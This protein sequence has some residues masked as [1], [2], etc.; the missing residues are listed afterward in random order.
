MATMVERL[1][2]VEDAVEQVQYRYGYI[3]DEEM[4]VRVTQYVGFAVR[5]WL[6]T[7]ALD[8]YREMREFVAEAA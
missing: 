2:L 3:T 8:Y 6:R 5:G 1:R 7:L 4:T